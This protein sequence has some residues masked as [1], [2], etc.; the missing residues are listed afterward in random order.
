MAT[1][2]IK[3]MN[4]REKIFRSMFVVSIL[5][6]M[7]TISYSWFMEGDN[8]SVS[9][10]H[11]DVEKPSELYFTI[12]D[13]ENKEKVKELQFEFADDFRLDSVAGNGKYFFTANLDE[14]GKVIE[15]VL[16]DEDEYTVN[17]IFYTDFEMFIEESTPVYLYTESSDDTPVASGVVGVDSSP[18]S[19]YG[20]FSTKYISGAVRLAILQADENGVY[21]PTFIWAPD[22][23]SELRKN[24]LDFEIIDKDNNE[25]GDG[26]TGDGGNDNKEYE[27][28]TYIT[29]NAERQPQEIIINAGSSAGTVKGNKSE[30]SEGS[31]GDSEGGDDADL[32]EE[33]VIYAWGAL[34]EKQIV[35][36]LVGGQQNKFRLVIWVDGNDRECHNALLDGLIF[37]SLHFGI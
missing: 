8:A 24:G 1:V 13:G 4:L 36:N 23:E 28:Y 37:V 11:M 32:A 15:Y 6:I 27:N 35:G 21:H 33:G 3:G 9:N 20:N 16:L 18:K 34:S 14:N 17:G 22:T 30:G 25:G 10:V 31:S 5:L 2:R 7:I 19:P 26:E 12:G 29:A